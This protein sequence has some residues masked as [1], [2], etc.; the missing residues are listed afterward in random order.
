MIKAKRA[1]IFK[2]FLISYVLVLVIPVFLGLMIY[3]QS[4][5]IISKNAEQSNLNRLEQVREAFE[6]NLDNAEMVLTQISLNPYVID[7]MY[8]QNDTLTD[9]VYKLKQITTSLSS[10]YF[11]NDFIMSY[12]IWYP[13]SGYVV[14]KDEVYK[15][16]AFFRTFFAVGSY[17]YQQWLQ[18]QKAKDPYMGFYK[19]SEMNVNG[20]R[21]RVYEYTVSIPFAS[22]QNTL[23]SIHVLIDERSVEKLMRN[24]G[25]EGQAFSYIADSDGNLIS[26][27][28]QKGAEPRVF[29]LPKGQ[30]SGYFIDH[31]E[32]ENNIVC[33][34]HS[35]DKE[36]V[37]VSAQSLDELL[38]QV[39]QTKKLF[40]WSMILSLTLALS[41]SFLLSYNKSRPLVKIMDSLDEYG[42]YSSKG[43][44]GGLLH[45]QKS[46]LSL[47]GENQDIREDMNR[48]RPILKNVFLFR[49][50][51]NEISGCVDIEANA[52]Q[53]GIEANGRRFSVILA[54]LGEFTNNVSGEV[55][56]ELNAVKTVLSEMIASTSS[57]VRYSG[58]D[59]DESTMAYIGEFPYGSSSE[60]IEYNM[61]FFS[62]VQKEM[63]DKYH[64]NMLFALGED[65]VGLPELHQSF[66]TAKYALENSVIRG[67]YS[68]VR[69]FNS[70]M[71]RNS[72]FDYPVET[73]LRL[74]SLAR[75]GKLNEIETVLDNIFKNNINNGEYDND[76]LKLLL[77]ALKSTLFRLNGVL[78]LN[79]P[80]IYK[81]MDGKI[82]ALDHLDRG[83]VLEIYKDICAEVIKK[84]QD[85]KQ[86]LKEEI[87]KYV[88]CNYMRQDFYL[89]CVT[90]HF[91]LS[92]TY[93]SI[94]FKENTGESFISY[95]EK[96]RMDRACT[97]LV[98][99]GI[100]VEEIASV[101]GYNS[102]HAFRRAFKRRYGM[103]PLEYKK[104]YIVLPN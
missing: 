52:L 6:I 57:D 89:G 29:E 65:V 46:V 70:S 67:E 28:P 34:T 44:G 101:V 7:F 43:H 99:S 32:N 91:K 104:A 50:M 39:S 25:G 75:E 9:T 87:I 85:L 37:Y 58:V 100:C 45:L 36:W 23:G 82:F 60:C 80:D 103:T 96:L 78:F 20:T 93:L 56:N 51:R 86:N 8:N 63:Y 18:E 31:T 40:I 54:Y 1:G 55:F 22:V 26:F 74:I 15:T 92:E 19:T 90:E 14:T 62:R 27:F 47:I 79:V 35:S 11:F 24:P 48:Q 77:D 69:M 73:E 59:L 94:F 81:L 2:N 88:N 12:Y 72:R 38:K 61:I 42:G 4:V 98:R 16:E 102:A 30:D 76:S 71:R 53:F 84:Q 66:E 10:Y 83:R 41:L 97:I 13:G 21:K 5:Q 68:G 3:Y 64:W 17:E 33:Y 49:L 95:V